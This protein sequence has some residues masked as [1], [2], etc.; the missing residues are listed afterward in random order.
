MK[1]DRSMVKE[2][3]KKIVAP[4]V[5]EFKGAPTLSIPLAGGTPF[6]FGS[7]KACAIVRNY[8][9][10]KLFAAKFP[11]EPKESAGD[12]LSDAQLIAMLTQRGLV[13]QAA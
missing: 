13:K 4:E 10:I 8:E 5:G 9:A 7:N 11:Y 1:G 6:T 12:S 2:E 3:R